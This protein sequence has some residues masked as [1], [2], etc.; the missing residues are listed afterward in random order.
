[1]GQL[2]W[3]YWPKPPVRQKFRKVQQVWTGPWRIIKFRTDVVDIIQHTLK[4]TKQT[5]HINRL[6]PCKSPEPQNLSTFDTP[7]EKPLATSTQIPA[8]HQASRLSQA[9]SPTTTISHPSLVERPRRRR[10]L[11]VTLEP[12]VL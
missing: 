2:V 12:Y 9:P 5:V 11:P 8:E 10:R 4:R 7:P 3:L 6:S 1:M